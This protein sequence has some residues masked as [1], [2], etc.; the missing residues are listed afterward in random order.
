MIH[1]LVLF[2]IYPRRNTGSWCG[3][4][5]LGDTGVWKAVCEGVPGMFPGYYFLYIHFYEEIA[6]FGRVKLGRGIK[7]T[8]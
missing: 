2:I 7:C 4:Q 5:K 1:L 3:A 8:D 6:K